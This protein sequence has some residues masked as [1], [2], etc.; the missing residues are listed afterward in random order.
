MFSREEYIWKHLIMLIIL[1][2]IICW[3]LIL[4]ILCKKFISNKSLKVHAFVNRQITI[5]PFLKNT[6]LIKMNKVFLHL[7]LGLCLDLVH[8]R[9]GLQQ[10]QPLQ[11]SCSHQIPVPKS[12]HLK[13]PKIIIFARTKS[14][15]KVMVQLLLFC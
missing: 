10:W 12:N 15:K 3:H 5:W 13:A 8:L 9:G 2:K 14:E 11:S 6:I 4:H 7:Y 1:C